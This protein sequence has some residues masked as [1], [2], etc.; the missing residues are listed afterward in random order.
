MN[1]SWMRAASGLTSEMKIADRFCHCIVVSRSGL[2]ADVGVCAT[3]K[4]VFPPSCHDDFE[5]RRYSI[6]L[7]YCTQ[8][9]SDFLKQRVGVCSLGVVCRVA[10]HERHQHGPSADLRSIPYQVEPSS[11]LCVIGRIET[12]FVL[13]GIE[14]AEH[15]ALAVPEWLVVEENHL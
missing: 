8:S 15:V 14:E 9:S 3:R 6:R 1:G 5:R 2:G 11:S 13:G 4:R 10:C 7:K 12:C